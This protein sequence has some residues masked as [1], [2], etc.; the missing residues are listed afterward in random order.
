M[1]P[2]AILE[3]VL[4]AADLEAMERFYARMLDLEV[5]TREKD[6]YV[7]F[8]CA[9]S[10]LLTFNPADSSEQDV[11]VGG[12]PIPRH[13]PTGPMHIAFAMHENEIESWKQ[14]LAQH[15]VPIEADV[16]WPNGARSIYF[17]DPAGHSVEL[18]TPTLWA[19]DDDAREIA[20]S[21]E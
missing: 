19:N 21:I 10:V 11:K 13:G 12:V 5:I 1:P 3:T 7:F 17:R 14:R 4:Y 16:H 20:A 2:P 15:D 18:A 6:R 9:A 8:R